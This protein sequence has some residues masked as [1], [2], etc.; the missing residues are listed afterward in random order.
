MSDEN[1]R[2]RQ[3]PTLTAEE[4]I[5][6]LRF[7]CEA[8]DDDREFG[9][10]AAGFVDRVPKSSAVDGAAIVA[11]LVEQGWLKAAVTDAFFMGEPAKGADTDG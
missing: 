10:M 8:Q 11:Q 3:P 5:E 2:D 4:A 6:G 7:A 1:E 9:T